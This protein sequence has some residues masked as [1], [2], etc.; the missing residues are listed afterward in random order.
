M[1][2]DLPT[3]PEDEKDLGEIIKEL[4]KKIGVL[5]TMLEQPSLFGL[6]GETHPDTIKVAH[7][8]RKEMYRVAGGVQKLEL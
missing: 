4:Q 8:I 3:T 5:I 2:H 7:E 1:S 6:G